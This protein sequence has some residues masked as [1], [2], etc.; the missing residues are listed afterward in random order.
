MLVGRCEAEA[1][2]LSFGRGESVGGRMGDEEMR[3]GSWMPTEE[4]RERVTDGRVGAGE[5]ESER[6]SGL[7]KERFE[8]VPGE[9]KAR[10]LLRPG[11]W[12]FKGDGLRLELKS[13]CSTF[14]LVFQRGL[15]LVWNMVGLWAR[16]P[17]VGVGVDELY[18]EYGE[19]EA[20]LGVKLSEVREL[21]A[22]VFRGS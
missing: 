4:R 6:P 17:G 20:L 19:G 2:T 22:E 14:G 1:C 12:V 9:R 18:F 11:E 5:K 3:R 7:G 15:S 8:L 10:E 16:L 13:M 21:E